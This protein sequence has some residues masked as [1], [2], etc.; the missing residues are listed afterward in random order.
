MDGTSTPSAVD[1]SS[2]DEFIPW[3][4]CNLCVGCV[5]RIVFIRSSFVDSIVY[6]SHFVFVL[7]LFLS[8]SLIRATI[9]CNSKARA[10]FILQFWRDMR[11][12][13]SFS[14]FY[15]DTNLLWF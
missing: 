3:K 4:Q 5:L 6:G 2:A 15:N 10:H 12:T 1:R 7:F 9:Q 14:I 13:R 8:L 11:A